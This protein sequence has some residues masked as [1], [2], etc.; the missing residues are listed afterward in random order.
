MLQTNLK[1]MLSQ[2]D[3]KV[4]NTFRKT[5]IK[6]GKFWARYYRMAIIQNSFH[7]IK[8]RAKMKLLLK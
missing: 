5:I 1:S 6:M 4:K 3:S 7:Q 8:I 2:E